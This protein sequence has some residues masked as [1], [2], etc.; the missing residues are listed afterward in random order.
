MEKSHKAN[1]IIVGGGAVGITMALALDQCL[2]SQSVIL[3]SNTDPLTPFTKD[4]RSTAYAPA[5]IRMLDTLGIWQE[6][7]K[8]SN[9]IANM[10]IT[11]PEPGSTVR[12]PLLHF[13]EEVE[14]YGALAHMVP[15]AHINAVLSQKLKQSKVTV[16]SNMDVTGYKD[17][18]SYAQLLCKQDVDIQADLIIAADGR[19]SRLRRVAGLP[20]LHHD[21]KQTA[22]VGTISHEHEH[23][24]EAW[25]YFRSSG[26]LALLPLS[27]KRSSIVWTQTPPKA[28]SLMSGDIMF[29]EM[30]LEEEVG[31]RL[32]TISFEGPL[33]AF[34]LSLLIA[35]KL[36]ASRLALIGD[37]GHAIHPL[38]GQGLNLG[39]KDVACLTELIKQGVSLG[40]AASDATILDKYER[41]R[42]VEVTRMAAVTGGLNTLFSNDL[43]FLRHARNF[44]LR[45]VNKSQAT[46][47]F[48]I[49]EAVGEDKSAPALL[50][51]LR[52]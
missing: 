4:L 20:T 3:L 48:F 45:L 39:L 18:G 31:G 40:L 5:V 43:N 30:E 7:E 42:R 16:L 10:Q 17:Q 19:N 47:S 35:T 22:I 13:E 49:D 27:G 44:G 33:Q 28:K 15:N 37:A 8:Q 29:A 21:Y 51:G 25:Q 26:P 41:K 32:G 1:I 9:P 46:K 52:P 36:N 38:A 11:D 23:H 34:P 14:K 24:N 12:I 2:P 6:F 50:R